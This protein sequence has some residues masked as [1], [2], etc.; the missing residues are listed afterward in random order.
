MNAHLLIHEPGL[1]TLVQDMGRRGYQGLGVPVSGALDRTALAAAN[2]VAG[3]PL[4]AAALEI[5]GTGPLIE[6]AAEGARLAVAGEG[7]RIEVMGEGGVAA[8]TTVTLGRGARARIVA[9][10]DSA[11]GYLAVAGGLAVPELL[12][13]RAT[14]ARAMLGGFR[15]RALRAGDRLPLGSATPPEGAEL[16]GGPLDLGR[17]AHLRVMAGSGHSDF[18]PGALDIFLSGTYQVTQAA[19]RMGLRLS[20]PVIATRGSGA[21]PSEGLA[22]GA[23]QVPGDGQ[24]ILLLADRQTTG[25]YP[26]IAHVI[27]ADLPAAGRLRAGDT[28]SFAAVDTAAARAARQALEA[29]L[30]AFGASLTPR[31]DAAIDAVALASA[32]L[33]SGVVSGDEPN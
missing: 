23:I 2:L 13:S 20:G 33:V 11:V 8:L 15:G 10:R 32:N 7:M 28:V 12:G 21:R 25:G 14:Y 16:T 26:C 19:D 31:G 29:A 3:N 27:S 22:D 18:E 9:P 6:I 1:R 5:A 24:P 30:A 17:P 4:S